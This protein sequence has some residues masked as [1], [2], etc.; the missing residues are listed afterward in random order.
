MS[1]LSLLLCL[2][3]GALSAS[4]F[5]HEKPE[6]TFPIWPDGKVPESRGT[7]PAKDIPTLTPYWPAADKATGA[8]MIVCP[9]GGYGKLADHEGRDYAL[10]LAERGI[11]GFVLKYRLGSHGY[12]HPAMMLDAQRAIR[13]IRSHAAEWN[14]D[15]GK[16]GIMGS[17]AG[18][19]LASTALTN[20]D[21]GNPSSAD[22][23]ERVSSRPDL[24]VL[25]YPVITMGEFTHKGS[26]RNLLGESPS[27][28][29]VKLL[30][31]ELQVTPRTPPCF[32]WHTRDDQGV[33]VRNALDFAEAL[34]KNQVPYEL[35]IPE[36]GKHGLGLGIRNYQPGVTDPSQLL[37]WTVVLDSWLKL[38]RF[39]P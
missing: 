18:G 19:H 3:W 15:P 4:A 20:F 36:K 9:G 22:E 37:P 39:I 29:L 11:A 21:A 25:C 6:A 12:R 23:I 31:N 1:R 28:D 38:H 26:K 5:S 27:A 2:L 10:W 35:Y 8:A 24:G 32:I 13:H 34:L 30:S 16:I 17:S 7:D 14:L 33:P